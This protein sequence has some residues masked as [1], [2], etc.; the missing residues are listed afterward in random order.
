[1]LSFLEVFFGTG[2]FAPNGHCY[3]GLTG[4]VGL[5]VTTDALL[6]IAGYS[7]PLTLFYC[8]LMPLLPQLLAQPSP[9]ELKQL[10]TELRES[11]AAIRALYDITADCQLSFSERFQRV[12]AMG[13]RHFNLDHG[14]L[15]QVQ[16]NRY[17][18]VNAH[19]P[20]GSIAP[21][22]IFDVRKTYCL[23]ALKSEAPICVEASSQSAWCLHP[24]F[25][26]FGM[27]RYIGM[28]IKV[29]GETYGV[30]CFCS[31]HPADRPFRAVDRQILK[32]MAQWVGGE[33]ER[34]QAVHALQKQLEQ[35]ALLKTI[36][37]KIRQSLKAEDI[38]QTAAEQVGQAFD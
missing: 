20:D 30:L 37:Q 22:D 21:G 29:S 5:H 35:A 32:L 33:L 6:A 19:T 17:E 36:T 26:S 28:R 1:M 11:E 3:L 23:E 9:A 4:L 13:C 7:I 24:G 27:E 34:Q 38:F 16:G 2:P 25:A 10:N 15:A 18:I 8:I 14:M 12:L 31:H